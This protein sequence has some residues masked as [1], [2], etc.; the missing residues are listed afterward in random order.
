MYNHKLSCFKC[1]VTNSAVP[2]HSQKCVCMVCEVCCCGVVCMCVCALVLNAKRT[3]FFTIFFPYQNRPRRSLGGVSIGSALSL[4][5]ALDGVG[6]K[7][8]PL[9]ALVSAKGPS[10]HCTGGRVGPK[11]VLDGCGKSRPHQC[12]IRG[13]SSH[14][15]VAIP[16]ELHWPNSDYSNKSK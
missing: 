9:A 11:D 5:S 2:M 14:W 3:Q 6:G 16:T 1:T 7:H 4:T 15:R 12:L 13:L 10:V 8:H